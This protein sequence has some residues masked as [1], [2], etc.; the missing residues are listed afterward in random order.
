MITF[1]KSQ[2]L[3]VVSEA[4]G[5]VVG[6]LDDF[7][8]DLEELVIYG[9][10]LKG[11][12]MFSK[13]GGIAADKL[14]K[15]GRDV[16]FITSEADV[17]WTTAARHAEEGRAWASQYAGTKVMSRRGAMMGEVDDFVF[18]PVQD[19]V[20]ALYLDHNRVVEIGDAVAT[21]PAACILDASA[22]HEVP[23]EMQE[24][25]HWWDRFTTSTKED[26]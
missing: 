5:A 9:Y 18:D 1:R 10:R 8:F 13:A 23:G 21:G 20:M 15:V 3:L 2:G 7:Q 4:E 26:E 22:V 25:R 17:E 6:K 11:A 12:G 16:V 24:P 14:V 19:K